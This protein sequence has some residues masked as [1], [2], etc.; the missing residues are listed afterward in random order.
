ME[1]DWEA[2]PCPWCP[3]GPTMPPV[4][5]MIHIAR[6]H[7]TM[8][9]GRL[10]A[11]RPPPAVELSVDDPADESVAVSDIASSTIY[12]Q[13]RGKTVAQIVTWFE[14]KDEAAFIALLI[15]AGVIKAPKCSAANRGDAGE[16]RSR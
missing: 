4:P 1:A 9:E 3:N 15:Q 14:G 2:R 7:T 11:P 13:L 10:P 5:L 16:Y 12:A 8:P 6:E